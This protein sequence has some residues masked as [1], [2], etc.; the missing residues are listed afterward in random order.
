MITLDRE[1]VIRLHKKLMDATG[2]GE[3]RL[4]WSRHCLLH[5][6]LLMDE[7]YCQVGKQSF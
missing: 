7:Q 3:M 1:N 6:R 4:C 2:G 5:S